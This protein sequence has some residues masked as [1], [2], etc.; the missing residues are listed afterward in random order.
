MYQE[1]KSLPGP[2]GEGIITSEARNER[3][4]LSESYTDRTALLSSGS[5]GSSSTMTSSIAPISRK[6]SNAAG[7]TP[8]KI[9]QQQSNQTRTT[10]I[11]GPVTPDTVYPV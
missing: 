8:Q 11:P 5:R 9:R 7:E 6:G 4:D 3:E 1:T 2:G 10:I